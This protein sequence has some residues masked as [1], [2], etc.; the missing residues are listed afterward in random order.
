MLA[1]VTFVTFASGFGVC[2]FDVNQID[3]CVE[4]ADM[5]VEKFHQTGD[6][7]INWAMEL[8]RAVL[9]KYPIK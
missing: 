9:A 4:H 3:A 5:W 1:G 2:L 8:V 7:I 6:H